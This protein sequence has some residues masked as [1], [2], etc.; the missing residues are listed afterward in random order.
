MFEKPW[1]VFDGCF[2]W[3]LTV[4]NQLDHKNAAFDQLLLDD[5]WVMENLFEALK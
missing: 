3:V 4:T 1:K 2:T 5:Q